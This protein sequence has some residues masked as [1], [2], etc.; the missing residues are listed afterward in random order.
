MQ[1]LVLRQSHITETMVS[2]VADLMKQLSHS[3]RKKKISKD[4]LCSVVTNPNTVILACI[5]HDTV[6]GIGSLFVINKLKGTYGYIEDM[7]VDDASRGKGVGTMI[8]AGLIDE[9]RRRGIS[10][11]ELSAR[12]ER[13]AAHALYSKHGFVTKDTIVYQK[14]LS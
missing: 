5:E 12:P 8:L 4:A 11:L 3:K 2:T 13:V 7:V 1:L 9:A 6:I 10:T 14:T